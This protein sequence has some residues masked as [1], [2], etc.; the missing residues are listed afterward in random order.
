MV[1]ETP[2]RRYLVLPPTP[3]RAG[4]E[5]SDAELDCVAGGTAGGTQFQIING[6]FVNCF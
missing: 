6:M 1:E 3:R 4:G 2:T 5:S